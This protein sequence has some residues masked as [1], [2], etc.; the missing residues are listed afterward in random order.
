MGLL[1]SAKTRLFGIG[2]FAVL[3]VLLAA[4]LS[5]HIAYN[6]TK[7]YQILSSVSQLQLDLFEL[8]SHISETRWTALGLLAI[9]RESQDL[10]EQTKSTTSVKIRLAEAFVANNRE[11]MQKIAAVYNIDRQLSG[12]FANLFRMTQIAESL[13]GTADQNEVLGLDQQIVDFYDLSQEFFLAMNN[14][15][16]AE[17][18]QL[19]I[20]QAGFIESMFNF[21]YA[22]LFGGLVIVLAVFFAVGSIIKSLGHGVWDIGVAACEMTASQAALMFNADKLIVHQE[23]CLSQS[24]DVSNVVLQMKDAY[25]KSRDKLIN[26]LSLIK[27]IELNSREKSHL[28]VQADLIVGC[29]V[30]VNL[31]MQHM[32]N[33]LEELKDKLNALDDMVF[34]TQLMSVNCAIEGAKDEGRGERFNDLAI[35][36]ASIANTSAKHLVEIKALFGSSAAQFAKIVSCIS[37]ALNEAKLL[38]QSANSVHREFESHISALA[39][40][41]TDLDHSLMDLNSMIATAVD[42]VS[43][44]NG[45]LGSNGALL[46]DSMEHILSLEKHLS[47]MSDAHQSAFTKSSQSDNERDNAVLSSLET[48]DADESVTDGDRVGNRIVSL[49]AYRDMQATEVGQGT[50]DR[51]SADVTINITA[52]RGRDQ[53]AQ[54]LD[55]VAPSFSQKA[56]NTSKAAS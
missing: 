40:Q 31:G 23:S 53:L 6:H 27:E 32:A 33:V 11:K 52:S 49:K 42:Q 5:R 16:K 3:I 8:N 51:R 9:Y 35:D 38:N 12:V 39:R 15:V 17:I 7:N 18:D 34:K 21:S 29:F 28:V 10:D 43:N 46:I 22:I 1:S 4:L 30:E 37:D 13:L 26:I 56:E 19:Q 14:V 54:D 44:I 2:L 48:S 41:L 47:A 50:L 36:A 55:V 20:R 24:K 45:V 25:L